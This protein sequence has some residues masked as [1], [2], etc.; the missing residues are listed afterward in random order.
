MVV[1]HDD[2]DTQLRRNLGN[3]FG[4]GRTTPPPYIGFN[5]LALTTHWSSPQA[6]GFNNH[7][8]HNITKIGATYLHWF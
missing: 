2:M 7:S 4:H 8:S 5:D 6:D 3:G 1:E